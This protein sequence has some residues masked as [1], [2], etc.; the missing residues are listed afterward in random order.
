MA[1]HFFAKVVGEKVAKS[2]E[3]ALILMH[4]LDKGMV[5]SEAHFTLQLLR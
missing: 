3:V 2:S 1:L 5:E 4:I